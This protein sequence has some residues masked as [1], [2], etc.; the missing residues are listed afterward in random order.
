MNMDLNEII[1]LTWIPILA[2]VMSTAAGIHM[3][4]IKKRPPYLRVKGD[5][6]VM[7][8]EEQYAKTGGILLLL[9]GLGAAG[10]VVLLFVN[11]YAA[12]A[13]IV[14]VFLI[15]SVKWRD[16]NRKYGPLGG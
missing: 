13:E 8:N 10:M 4:L 11:A 3:L 12:L 2:F 16:M 9:F 7:Q 15:F 6:R 5:N 1:E 14:V